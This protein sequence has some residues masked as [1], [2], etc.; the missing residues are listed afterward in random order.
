MTGE[1]ERLR[2]L[3]QSSV[4][5][6]DIKWAVEEID[7]L[8][9]NLEEHSRALGEATDALERAALAMQPIAA[10]MDG[11]DL[12]DTIVLARFGEEELTLGHLRGIYEAF[13]GPK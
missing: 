2:K 4:V 12:P 10:M 8:R 13:E 7:W 9:R 3:A 1:L 11:V 6:A 5:G